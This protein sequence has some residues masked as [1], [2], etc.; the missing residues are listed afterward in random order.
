VRRVILDSAMRPAV[1]VPLAPAS[2]GSQSFVRTAIL[3]R[4][5]FLFLQAAVEPF[6]VAVTFRVATAGS[7]FATASTRWFGDLRAARLDQL[8]VTL[9]TV[10]EPNSP[11]LTFLLFCGHAF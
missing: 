9:L 2:D 10:R 8:H 1:I 7:L 4:P 5:D 11:T 3:R 6:D